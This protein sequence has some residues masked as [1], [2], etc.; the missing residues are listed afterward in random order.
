MLEC[1]PRPIQVIL[2]QCT[3]RHHGGLQ[4]KEYTAPSALFTLDLEFYQ[5]KGGLPWFDCNMAILR[6]LHPR[7][8]E[9]GLCRELDPA[10]HVVHPLV[11]LSLL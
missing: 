1:D 7:N 5:E 4:R 10:T 2:C 8:E 9:S 11:D 6:S 3:P